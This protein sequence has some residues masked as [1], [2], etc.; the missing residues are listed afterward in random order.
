MKTNEPVFT[1]NAPKIYKKQKAAP[2]VCSP[3]NASLRTSVVESQG[4]ADLER[5]E[6]RTFSFLE[7]F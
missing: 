4:Y 1:G 7:H 2:L 6:L 5:V 3:Y